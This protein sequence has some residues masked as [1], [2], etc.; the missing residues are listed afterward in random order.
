MHQIPQLGRSYWACCFVFYL[1][2]ALSEL[3][4]NSHQSPSLSGLKSRNKIFCTMFIHLNE[5]SSS[6]CCLFL[7][8][9][10]C[11]LYNH[12]VLV[13]N[14]LLKVAKF[15]WSALKLNFLDQLHIIMAAVTGIFSFYPSLTK[16]TG[17]KRYKN[18][19][20]HSTICT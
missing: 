13:S 1:H 19:V 10:V 8:G 14:W 7:I 2:F 5:P 12:V 18:Q 17:L 20:W 3:F 15:Q 16:H 11:N 6:I 4:V 9:L